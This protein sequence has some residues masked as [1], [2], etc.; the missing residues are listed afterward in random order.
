MNWRMMLNIA[1]KD[2]KEIRYNRMVWTPALA[3]PIIF[4]VLLPLVLLSL[5][6][7]EGASSS[8][9]GRQASAQALIA[10]M[11]EVVGKQLVGMNGDQA[12]VV[13]LLGFFLAPLFLMIPLLV[14]SVIGADSIVGEKERKTLEALLYIP[15]SDRELYLAKL[16]SSVV[17]AIL[18][19]WVSFGVYV[20][21]ANVIGAPLMQ[22]VWFPLPHWY[23]LIFWVSPAVATLG[24]SVIVLISSRVSTFVGAQQVSGLVAMPIVLLVIG[25]VVGIVALGVLEVFIIGVVIWLVDALLIGFGM[26]QFSRSALMARI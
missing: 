18:V 3:T 20:I 16:I 7:A 23:P 24:M 10:L 22:R 9:L 21:I 5:A 1:L 19:A 12:M 6:N 11:P 14:S 17:P 2:W 4:A 26:K 13:L 8:E 25:Q 15:A